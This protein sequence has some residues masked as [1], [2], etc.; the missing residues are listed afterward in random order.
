MIDFTTNPEADISLWL[1]CATAL[2][3][4][5]GAFLTLVGTLG[6]VRLKNFYNRTHAPTLGATLGAGCVLIAAIL[7]FSVV[8][9][10]PVFFPILI[11]VFLTIT[12]P[13]TLI[14]LCRTALYR[15][16]TEGL[17]KMPS[18]D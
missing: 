16:R 15:D 4:L 6:L 17:Q 13:V 9:G 7:Y 18:D 14:L 10:K 3:V 5:L 2:L 12:T 8:E 1:A 11:A